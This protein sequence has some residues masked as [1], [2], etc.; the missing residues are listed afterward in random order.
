METVSNG[1]WSGVGGGLLPLHLIHTGTQAHPHWCSVYWRWMCLDE[2]DGDASLQ[3]LGTPMSISQQIELHLVSHERCGP[4]NRAIL[5]VFVSHAA[6]A[7][8]PHGPKLHRN[9]HACAPF[10]ELFQLQSE[11]K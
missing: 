7:T 9:L 10:A 6:R 4:D 8:L 11:Q 2:A 1:F 3:S 5:M